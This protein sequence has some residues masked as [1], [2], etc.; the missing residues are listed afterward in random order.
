[1][2]GRGFAAPDWIVST[3]RAGVAALRIGRIGSKGMAG[4]AL[5]G[6]GVEWWNNDRQ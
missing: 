4:A 3:G 1:M 5:Q 2:K 6:I